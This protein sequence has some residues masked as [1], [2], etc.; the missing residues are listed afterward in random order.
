M[1][2]PN[3]A[4]TFARI[5]ETIAWNVNALKFFYRISLA[6]RVLFDRKS[7]WDIFLDEMRQ[8]LPQKPGNTVGNLFA[9]IGHVEVDDVK[10]QFRERPKITH[11]KTMNGDWIDVNLVEVIQA[12]K[13]SDGSEYDRDKGWI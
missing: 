6:P 10:F 2:P 8:A 1:S 3:A 13:L 11:V 9:A 12:F 5:V 4:M 7:D